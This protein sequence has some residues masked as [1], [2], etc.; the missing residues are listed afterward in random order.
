MN[1]KRVIVTGG[2][3][4]LGSALR[5]IRPEFIYLTRA[6]S[7]LTNPRDVYGLF[8]ELNP[9][10]VVHLA[11]KVGG[12]KANTTTPFDFIDQ[13][14]KLNQAVLGYTIRHG[15]R[16]IYAS[17]TCVYPANPPMYPLTEGM[18]DLGEPEPTNDAYAYAKRHGAYMLR[19]GHKQYR[20]PF[21]ILYLCNLF[22]YGDMKH[23][24]ER[25]HFVTA[26]V[27]KVLKAK[28]EKA[29]SITLFGDGTPLRQFI[30]ADDAAK[31][32]SLAVDS[33]LTGEYNI[34][35]SYNMSI[36]EMAQ[37][38]A[39]VFDYDGIIEFNNDMGLNGVYRKDAS[40]YKFKQK[41]PEF[42]IASF[43]SG[44]RK[45]KEEI[46]HEHFMASNAR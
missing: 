37:V 12:I 31:A 18:V 42:D 26:M 5:R 6:D 35:P 41:F 34:A 25:S 43:E 29:K 14:T 44:I 2:G 30:H 21:C 8:T 27:N 1:D 32:I 46:Q 40:L 11:G 16:T 24:V 4:L 13:N 17:S 28:E 23:G 38:I 19:S 33:E 9:Y 39:S 45:L 20:T 10:T 15:I 36:K 7:D 22:G 3:G